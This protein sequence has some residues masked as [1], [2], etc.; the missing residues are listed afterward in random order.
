MK[1]NKNNKNVFTEVEDSLTIKVYTV[2]EISELVKKNLSIFCTIFRNK[3]IFNI[4][5]ISLNLMTSALRFDI[6]LFLIT[7]LKKKHTHI[8]QIHHTYI[9][10]NKSEF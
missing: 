4:Y 9:Y 5:T 2:V 3:I 1:Y 8:Q 7:I 10:P 6:Q